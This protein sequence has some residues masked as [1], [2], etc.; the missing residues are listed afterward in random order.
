MSVLKQFAQLAKPYWLSR[1]SVWSWLI[2]AATVA[3]SLLLVQVTVTLNLWNKEFFDALA[4]LDGPLI[5]DLLVKFIG[6]VALIVVMKVYAKWLQQWV[7]IRWRSWLTER[8]VS[9]WMS[10]QNFYHL[11]LTGEPDNP[12]QRIAEDI[13]LLTTDTLELILG[14]IKSVATLAAFSVILWNLSSGFLLPLFDD[15]KISGYLLWLALIY[16]VLGAFVTHFFGRKLH[17]LFYQQQKREANFRAKLLRSRD[18]AEQIALMQ[19]QAREQAQLNERFD[20]ITTN[21]KALMGREKKLGIVVNTYHQIAAMVPYFAAIPALM[22]KAIT[23]GGLFQVKMAFMKVYASLSWFIFRYDDLTRWSATVVRLGQFLQAMEACERQQQAKQSEPAKQD[24][25]TQSAQPTTALA[26]QGLSVQR[27]NGQPLLHDVHL[28]LA[29]GEAVMVR[30]PSG[31][32]KS[33][34]LRT[35]AGVWPFYEGDYQ[36]SQPGVLLLPQKPYLPQSSVRECLSY[37]HLAE[38]DDGVYQRALSL[39]G[40]ADLADDLSQ[41]REWSLQLSGGELQKL[42]LARALVQQPDTLILDEATSSLDEPTA[43]KLLAMVREQLPHS[44]ILMVSHQSH[45]LSLF[46][47]AV[48]LT[49]FAPQND[50]QQSEQASTEIPMQPASV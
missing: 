20:A 38:L 26:W 8:L 36:Q 4:A 42:A 33:T 10:Q 2:F 30:G 27:P 15:I 50:E 16:S 19:G 49:Q 41:V 18:S 32:G 28:A 12:D 48:D 3:L 11:T 7:E 14:L 39:V 43:Y 25:K 29:K 9:R 13:K 46:D 31:L 47:R 22:A 44:Q 37:P 17:R 5:Y 21:W 6:I 34:L 1:A 23:V 24:Q 35:L 45:L 40:L